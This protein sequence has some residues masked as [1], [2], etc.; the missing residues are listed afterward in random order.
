MKLANTHPAQIRRSGR[1]ANRRRWAL[2]AGLAALGLTAAMVTPATA[3][4]AG[5][6]T[7]TVGSVH[8][9]AY[10]TD[11]PASAFIDTDGTFYFQQS[12]ALYGKNAPRYWDFYS[13]S[14]FDHAQRSSALSDAVNPANPKDRNNDTTWRCNHSPTGKHATPS[15][16]TSYYSQ[17][18]YCDLIGTWVDPDTG[19]WYGVVHNE[20]TPQTFGS[21]LHYD[22]LDYAV[23]TD[24]GRTWTIKDH[25]VTSP[26][27]T[28]RDDTSAFPEDTWDYGDGDPRLFV[29]V[30]SGYFYLYYGSR[31]LN[32]GGIGDNTQSNLAHVARA[33]ISK[34]MA[35]GSWHKF[36]D[37]SWN[38]PGIGGKESDLV[39]TAEHKSGYVPPAKEYDPENTGTVKEQ[40]QAGTVPKT[41]K[42]FLTNV[43]W[44]AYLG[45]YIGTPETDG[46]KPMPIYA[47]RN[48]GTQQ[49]HLLGTTGKGYKQASWY[50]WMV[51][52]K[53]ASTQGLLGK[54]FRSY[55]SINCATSSGEWVNITI[56]PA[57]PPKPLVKQKTPY[58]IRSRSNQMLIQDGKKATTR[59]S[60][61][62]DKAQWRFSA[63]GDGSY[64][65]TNV[66]SGDALGVSSTGSTDRAWGTHPGVSPVPKDGPK[67]GQQWFITQNVMTPRHKGA[68]RLTHTYRLVNR[69]SGLTLSLAG[70]TAADTTPYRNWTNKTGNT[71]GGN[72]KAADQTLSLL[73]R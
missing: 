42:L 1:S 16:D 71:I 73:H 72:R 27:S 44:N 47:T 39:P 23:S 19:H 33:P 22:S 48:L 46:K 5:K 43:A 59:R 40:Q 2:P 29:D 69:Y 11:T 50:R 41:S 28:K 32:K 49:W 18:N 30:R 9:Y 8:S 35:K 6:D 58:T 34:K 70:G 65:I 4:A 10:P 17:R 21:G 45:E 62:S 53:T 51:D 55:C 66:D 7:I 63:N 64:T 26:Y 20:F 52:A 61:N 31:I 67:V 3:G 36:Y 57:K 56:N 24:H 12:A 13:G 68:T 38:Q 37:G 60:S 15:P 54:T 25:I 14:D